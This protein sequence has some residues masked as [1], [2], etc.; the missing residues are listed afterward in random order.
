LPTAPGVVLL[1]IEEG[2]QSH[3]APCPSSSLDLLKEEETLQGRT[4]SSTCLELL[5]VLARPEGVL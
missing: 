3:T 1:L 5:D 4:S 2:G